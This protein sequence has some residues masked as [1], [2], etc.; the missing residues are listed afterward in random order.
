MLR[1]LDLRTELFLSRFSCYWSLGNI[2]VQFPIENKLLAPALGTINSKEMK[3]KRK[4]L[5][6][7][8]PETKEVH[9][10]SPDT[11]VVLS[12]IALL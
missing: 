4:S 3:F 9:W 6:K 2:P 10:F 12:T 11:K 7:S 5:T 8:M 1:P